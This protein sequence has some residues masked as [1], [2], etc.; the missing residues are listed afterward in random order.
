VA[1]DPDDPENDRDE[2][3]KLIAR[4]LSKANL[5]PRRSK[6]MKRRPSNFEPFKYKGEGVW[7]GLDPGPEFHSDHS[8][9]SLKLFISN[10]MTQVQTQNPWLLTGEQKPVL[11]VGGAIQV[12]EGQRILHMAT[13]GINQVTEEIELISEPLFSLASWLNSNFQAFTM[14]RGNYGIGIWKA[15]EGALDNVAV[16]VRTSMID[17]TM[18][19]TGTF[20]FLQDFKAWLKTQPLKSKEIMVEWVFGPNYREMDQFSLPL[21]LRPEIPGVYPWMKESI[22]NYTSRFMAAKECV[23]VLKG[24]PGTGK[25]SFIKR[26]IEA[27]KSSAMVTY[28]TALLFSDGFFAAFMSRNNCNLLIIEDAD[29]M[30]TSRSEGNELMDKLLNASD[31]LIS[32]QHKKIIFSTNLPNVSTIDPA[33]LRQGRCFDIL[34]FRR[35]T[36]DEAKIVSANYYGREEPLGDGR[37][38]SVA[39]I[40]N[41]DITNMKQ[42]TVI[43]RTGF[44]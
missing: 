24:S 4:T 21:Q 10:S 36:R 15:G 34:D 22:S 25:T 1:L 43:P 29:K 17:V 39:E 37:D 13:A 44:I 32:M 12:L 42:G 9:L 30:L 3:Q 16:E 33:L 41:K 2:I 28:D 31:G 8:L 5:R 40:T 27:S 19:V 6:G 23:L 35:L 26:M 18:S 7:E 38:F 14:S 11:N 20:Q